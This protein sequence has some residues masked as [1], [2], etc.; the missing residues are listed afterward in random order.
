MQR[1]QRNFVDRHGYWHLSFAT[2]TGRGGSFLVL[3]KG[4]SLC[5]TNNDHAGGHPLD[6]IAHLVTDASLPAT[7]RS[8]VADFQTRRIFLCRPCG[9]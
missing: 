7:T 1:L 3:L 9:P 2:A 4:F 5:P 6:E 8:D